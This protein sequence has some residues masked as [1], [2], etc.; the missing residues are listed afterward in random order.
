MANRINHNFGVKL[1]VDNSEGKALDENPS[2]PG[3]AWLARKW[4]LA[5]FPE[6]SRCS[7][8]EPS[9]ETSADIFIL[10]DFFQEL[11]PRIGDQP[12]FRHGAM[13][14][15]S[16]KTSSRSNVSTSPLPCAA[17][18]RSISRAHASSTSGVA[19]STSVSSN[20]STSRSRSCGANERPRSASS[21]TGSGIPTLPKRVDS[22]PLPQRG[23]S[24]RCFHLIVGRLPVNR[25]T[26]GRK[27][28]MSKISRGSRA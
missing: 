20:S 24:H 16:D 21:R 25:Q 28:S 8:A 1:N 11:V 4:Q 26:V 14:R 18:R 19:G 12:D 13:R 2:R 22:L 7:H 6:S 15:A 17:T 9:T 23:Y 10:C 27:F 5:R 3:Y